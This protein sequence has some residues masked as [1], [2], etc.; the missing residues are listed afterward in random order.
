VTREAL[1]ALVD[2][3]EAGLD[4]ELRLLR[5]LETIALKQR[6]VSVARNLD[7]FQEE[8]ARRDRLTNSLLT[9]EESLRSIRTALAAHRREAAH[10]PGYDRV[11]AKHRE[12]QELVARI[13]SADGDSFRALAEAEL[14]RRVA[15]ASLE[16]GEMTLAAYRKVLAPPADGATLVD[17]RG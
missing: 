6:D 9:I 1:A 13:L 7:A 10:V 16:Q 5:P 8:S 2:E 15:L 17:E 4:A 12:A 3:Y 11:A 14:A